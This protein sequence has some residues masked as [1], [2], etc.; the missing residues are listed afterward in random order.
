MKERTD[1]FRKVTG[2]IDLFLIL[3]EKPLVFLCN[4]RKCIFILEKHVELW[5]LF[6]S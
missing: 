6:Y 4:N 5:L 3:R 1:L 2:G